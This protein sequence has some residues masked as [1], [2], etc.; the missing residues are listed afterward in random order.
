VADERTAPVEQDQV[1]RI[2][3][4]EQSKERLIDK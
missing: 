1:P 4:R 2:A 3:N